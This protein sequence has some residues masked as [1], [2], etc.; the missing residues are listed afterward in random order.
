MLEGRLSYQERVP[1]GEDP[2]AKA[3]KLAHLST[4]FI[5]SD[6]FCSTAIPDPEWMM[7]NRRYRA[8]IADPKSLL[9]RQLAIVVAALRS[10]KP[11]Q[12]SQNWALCGLTV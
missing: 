7:E 8:R 12:K 2:N 10:A 9:R 4:F 1:R 6:I 11:A 5:L 3:A